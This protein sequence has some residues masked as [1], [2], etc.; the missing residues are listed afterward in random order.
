M[1][2]LRRKAKGADG[3]LPMN[4]IRYI[5]YIL[6]LGPLITIV[7]TASS[8][9]DDRFEEAPID[10]HNTDADN[11]VSRLQQRVGD[12]TV[13]LEHDKKFGY[14]IS[15]LEQLDI[16]R[17]SQVLVFSKTSFQHRYISP[18]TPRAIYFNDDIYIGTV[19]GGD[20]IELSAADPKLGTVFYTLDQHIDERPELVR[21]SH[22]CLQCHASTLTRG[23]PGHLVRSVYTDAEGFPILKVGSHLTTQDSP[24]KERW[25]G[26]YVTGTH[27]AARHLGNEIAAETQR[28]ATIDMEAGANR[29]ALDTRVNAESYLT[30][31]SDIVALMVL[32]HQTG[33]HN[34]LTRADFETRMAL[35]RQAVTD[36]IFERDP[37]QLSESTQSIIANIGDKLI[38]YMLY[39]NEI[40]LDDPV[41][42]TSGF[43]EAFAKRGPFDA[44]GRSLREFD[45]QS[46]MFKYPLSYLIYSPQFDGLPEPMKAY[47]YKHLWDILT[48]V[49]DTDEYLHLTNA[50][51]RAIREILIETKPGLPAYWKMGAGI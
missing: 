2:C 19:P 13:Q 51:S 6:V 3:Q 9:A 1:E 26:W 33:M 29:M 5:S 34:L 23:V 43:A 41:Q 31:Q 25:G 40:E 42:G 39:V 16:P 47:V 38:A 11:P 30:P 46:R 21:Q 49:I 10:Y 36:K 20:V 37:N 12:G 17:E 4:A 50:K 22:N 14:L 32:E 48:G 18:E 44:Q 28:S 7:L 24:F 35:H 27:G 45:L 8:Y 15:I